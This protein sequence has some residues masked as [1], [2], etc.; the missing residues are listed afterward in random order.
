VAALTLS[1][2]GKNEFSIGHQAVFK[3]VLADS[4]AVQPTAI[5]IASIVDATPL[6]IQGVREGGGAYSG[7]DDAVLPRVLAAEVLVRVVE[8]SVVTYEVAGVSAAA[9]EEAESRIVSLASRWV[10]SRIVSL[11]SR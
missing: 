11:A 2:L 9:A 8:V 3:Q 6:S 4:I 7:D 5:T 10:E 1:G